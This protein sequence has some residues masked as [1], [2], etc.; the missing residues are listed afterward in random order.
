MGPLQRE[1][2]DMTRT[3]LP[4]GPGSASAGEMVVMLMGHFDKLERA[5][6]RLAAE[7]DRLREGSA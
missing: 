4:P 2:Y 3:D 5:L 6:L 7:I 1:I